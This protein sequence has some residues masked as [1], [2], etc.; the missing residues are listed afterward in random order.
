MCDST[1][2]DPAGNRDFADRPKPASAA[3]FPDLIA[4]TLPTDYLIFRLT[5]ANAMI[6]T[7]ASSRCLL[8]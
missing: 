6:A 1:T 5:R 3:R 4:V 2:T 7:N 8:S